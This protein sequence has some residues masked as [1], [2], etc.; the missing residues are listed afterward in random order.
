MGN[1]FIWRKVSETEPGV[2]SMGLTDKAFEMLGQIWA[3]VP[4]S[5]RKRNFNENE[6]LFT[7][8]GSDTLTT[9]TA[10][11]DIKRLNYDGKALE[12]PDELTSNTPLMYAEV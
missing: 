11:F 9:I 12:R 5:D 4:I 3:I 10:P 1:D 7:V 6:S 8:E 2:V